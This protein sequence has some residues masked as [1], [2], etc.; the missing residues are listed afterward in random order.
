MPMALKQQVVTARQQTRMGR[1]VDLA[2]LSSQTMGDAALEG[3]VLSM[4]CTQSQIYL[5]MMQHSCDVTNR[6]RAAHSLKGAARSIGAFALADRAA[7]V[8][9]AIHDGYGAVETELG[10]VLDYIATLR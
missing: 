3:E 6:I 5:K 10:R 4:F 7:E 8:E 2:H 9:T 1:P